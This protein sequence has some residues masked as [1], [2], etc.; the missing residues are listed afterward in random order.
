MEE[1]KIG[2]LEQLKCKKGKLNVQCFKGFGEM[3]LMQLCEIIFDL[4]ICCLV[5]LVISDEDE[6]Q[7]MVIMDMLLVKKCLE[8]C[9]NWLQE[10]GDMV[11]LEV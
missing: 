9:C 11:D 2:V 5:Q 4:N 10:K 7:I 3:N 1:E 6:Q 8:D